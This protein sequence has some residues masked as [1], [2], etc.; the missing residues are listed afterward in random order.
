MTSTRNVILLVDDEPGM[1]QYYQD[2]IEIEDY[3]VDQNLEVVSLDDADEAKRWIEE[4]AGEIR[5][6]VFDSMMPHEVPFD[7][8][9]DEGRYTGVE[10]YKLLRNM[11]PGIEVFILTNIG[12]ADDR[13]EDAGSSDKR[14]HVFRK[15]ANI[16]DDFGKVLCEILG[17]AEREDS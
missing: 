2:Q 16:Y 5:C 9:T 1:A 3:V 13:L 4:H 17:E 8:D 10:L 14:L 7:G 15:L 12:S 11:V 6:A